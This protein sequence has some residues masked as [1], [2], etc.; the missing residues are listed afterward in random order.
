MGTV[1]FRI[2]EGFG[3]LVTDIARENL[4]E[5][6]DLDKGVSFLTG[7]FGMSEEN[8]LSVISGDSILVENVKDQTVELQPAQEDSPKFDIV[9]WLVAKH[10]SFIKDAEDWLSC[11]QNIDLSRKG[12]VCEVN[13]RLSALI[14][15]YWD[16][17][18]EDLFSHIDD[19][20]DN[21]RYLVTGVRNFLD[22]YC[23]FLN[24]Y[25]RILVLF[26][27][28]F[29]DAKKPEVCEEVIALNKAVGALMMGQADRD[30][31]DAY[32]TY[33]DERLKRYLETEQE[34]SSPDFQVEP[35]SITDGYDAGWLA[36]NGD[37]YGLRGEVSNLLHIRIASALQAKGIIPTPL[38]IDCTSP[39]RWLET[40]GWVKIH[41]EHILFDGYDLYGVC[42]QEISLTEKQRDAIYRYGQVCCN[43]MLSFGP[44]RV[45]ISA[46]RFEMTE[47]LMLKKLF[48]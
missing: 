32:L 29:R 48:L 20:L 31:S 13:L 19:D 18:V 38:P 8:A 41:A 42:G 25:N 4:T 36:P 46:A 14:K 44:S 39:E 6:G 45:Q 1:Q 43:G 16:G 37:Y 24:L 23:G 12:P 40:N 10:A 26:S 2:G 17:D 5:N 30:T 47:P 3:K 34:L 22:K 33:Y 9:A 7:S 35:V 21:L 11:V 28:K 15:Y 27:D